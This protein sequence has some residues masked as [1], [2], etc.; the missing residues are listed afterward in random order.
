MLTPAHESKKKETKP[1]TSSKSF[2]WEHL[3]LLCLY[4]IRITAVARDSVI[5]AGTLWSCHSAGGLTDD[6]ETEQDQSSGIPEVPVLQSELYVCSL[7]LRS[8]L[9]G[10]TS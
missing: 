8:R 9:W 2:G 1:N 4:H 7:T 5:I 6:L 10:F 3:L